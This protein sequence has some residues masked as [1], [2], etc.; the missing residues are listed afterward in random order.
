MLRCASSFGVA[1]YA[2]NMPHFSGLARLAFGSFYG[3]ILM[4][5]YLVTFVSIASRLNIFADL[6]P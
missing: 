2:K 5:K 4:N 1:A 3:V 6:L